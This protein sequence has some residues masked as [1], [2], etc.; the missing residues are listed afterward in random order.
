MPDNARMSTAPAPSADLSK[1]LQRD[2]DEARDTVGPQAG[3]SR[4]EIGIVRPSLVFDVAARI[5]NRVVAAARIVDMRRT[6]T[7][8]QPHPGY[9]FGNGCGEGG[10]WPGR[11]RGSATCMCT[12]CGARARLGCWRRASGC[13]S[14]RGGSVT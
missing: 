3:V 7:D 1:D 10:D 4:D 2:F 14:S 11:G 9:V 5:V 12:T 6:A 13:M 8:G